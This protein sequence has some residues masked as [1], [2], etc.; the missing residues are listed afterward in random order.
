[1]IFTVLKSPLEE[2]EKYKVI[3][4]GR[5]YIHRMEKDNK[6]VVKGRR[7]GER[8][9]AK[10]DYSV[11]WRPLIIKPAFFIPGHITLINQSRTE[12]YLDGDPFDDIVIGRGKYKLGLEETVLELI[13]GRQ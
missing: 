2:R 9:I 3:L 5:S 6:I 1:M 7:Y 12:I 4:N 10:E 11:S 8:V 13:V